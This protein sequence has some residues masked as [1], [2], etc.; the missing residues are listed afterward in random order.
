MTVGPPLYEWIQHNLFVFVFII[1]AIAAVGY[2]LYQ[3][4]SKKGR[5]RQ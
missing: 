1:G 3:A 5:Y 4:G 2:F